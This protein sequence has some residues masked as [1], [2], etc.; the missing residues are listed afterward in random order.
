LKFKWKA[1]SLISQ[2]R[3]IT[4]KESNNIAFEFF[5]S[6]QYSDLFLT[7][8]DEQKVEK[9]NI[10]R[11]MFVKYNLIKT[12]LTGRNDGQKNGKNKMP[13]I[14]STCSSINWVPS[15]NPL[16]F[17]CYDRIHITLTHKLTVGIWWVFPTVP[18]EKSAENKGPQPYHPVHV[19]LSPCNTFCFGF[20]FVWFLF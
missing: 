3:H 17:F 18:L 2:C 4:K 5:K 6:W 20:F 7:V 16:F 15:A 19:V 1:S 11:H 12:Y 9:S 13:C 8:A 10:N 14:M